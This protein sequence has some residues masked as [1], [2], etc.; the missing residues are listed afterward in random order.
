MSV[1]SDSAIL[2]KSCFTAQDARTR[3]ESFESEL[4]DSANK[5]EDAIRYFNLW[6]SYP[7]LRDDEH[8]I[9]KNKESIE[10]LNKARSAY[11]EHIAFC[12]KKR[13]QLN[14]IHKTFSWCLSNNIP[15]ICGVHVLAFNFACSEFFYNFNSSLKF[16]F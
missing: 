12:K 5:L 15:T 1:S 8:S 2:L 7:E 14:D 16:E 4:K 10:L 9:E 11:N 3:M 13:E 6:S